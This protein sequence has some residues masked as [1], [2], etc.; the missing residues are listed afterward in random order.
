MP[1]LSFVYLIMLLNIFLLVI[2]DFCFIDSFNTH[3][4]LAH[5]ITGLIIVQYNCNL[6][7]FDNNLLSNIFG[8][9]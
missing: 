6:A 2:N 8:L 1:S 7:L 3:V 4:L 5:V 9:A